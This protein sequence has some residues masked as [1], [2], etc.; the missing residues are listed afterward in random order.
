MQVQLRRCTTP[1]TCSND[2]LRRNL[3]HIAKHH[4]RML[5]SYRNPT[6]LI[7]SYPGHTRVCARPS[8]REIDRPD[9]SRIQISI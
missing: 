3:A 7:K 1:P 8:R 6:K 9:L 4:R 2:K 5:H